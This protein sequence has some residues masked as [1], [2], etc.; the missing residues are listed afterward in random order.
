M[1][2]S[3]LNGMQAGIQQLFGKVAEMSYKHGSN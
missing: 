1:V 2:K 3:I